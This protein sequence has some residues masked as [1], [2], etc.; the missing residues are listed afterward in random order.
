MNH[1]VIIAS[2]QGIAPF[3][4]IGLPAAAVGVTCLVAAVI[5]ALK[6][7]KEDNRAVIMLGIAGVVLLGVFLVSPSLEPV[8]DWVVN[9]GFKPAS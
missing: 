9:R 4:F 6:K 7:K 2:G 5:L 8:T 1:P 3:V